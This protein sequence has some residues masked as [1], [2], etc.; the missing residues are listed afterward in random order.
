MASLLR[1]IGQIKDQNTPRIISQHIVVDIRE[2]AVFNL[3][4]RHVKGRLAIACNDIRGL[5]HIDPRITCP[6]GHN[7]IE[8]H[9]ARRHRIKPV[10]SVVDIRPAGPL[11]PHPHKSDPIHTFGFDGV[12]FGVL[13]GK[14]TQ[15]GAVSCD[16][17]PL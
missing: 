11:Y 15:N 14:V 1:N 7:T 3:K 12:T 13:N 2:M 10:G 9:V 5:A 8:Q 6:D 16:K 4:P 17:K